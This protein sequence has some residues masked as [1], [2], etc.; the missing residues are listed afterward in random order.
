MPRTQSRTTM[1]TKQPA[2]NIASPAPA[3]VDMSMFLQSTRVLE[4]AEELMREM[5]RT[6][7]VSRRDPNVLLN[8]DIFFGV[9]P[10]LFRS[11]M[12]KFVSALCSGPLLAAGVEFPP[13]SGLTGSS[14]SK[15]TP[16][17]TTTTVATNKRKKT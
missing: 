12:N 8:A 6:T 10:I 16:K 1:A 15:E 4:D 3:S 9:N 2:E 14:K 11:Q 13:I 7:K 5:L 17:S